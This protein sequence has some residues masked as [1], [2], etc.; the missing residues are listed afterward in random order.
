MST[1]ICE[2]NNP[3]HHNSIKT[4]FIYPGET[5]HVS[6]AAVGQRD[7]LVPAAVGSRMDR[8]RLSTFQYVQQTTKTCTMLNYTVFSKEDVSIELIQMAHVQHIVIN[9]H[10][11]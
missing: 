4:F 10:F 7:G 9:C 3:N 1:S 5:F 8:G 2:D 6:V 11:S